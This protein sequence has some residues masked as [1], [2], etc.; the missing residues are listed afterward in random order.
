MTKKPLILIV[1]LIVLVVSGIVVWRVEDTRAKAAKI[2]SN[3]LKGLTTD[4]VK[5]IVENQAL[6]DPSK[7]L[8]IVNSTDSRKAFM[9]GL[10]EYLALA[11]KARRE[12]MAD[13]PNVKLVLQNKEKGLLTDLYLTKAD[14]DGKVIDRVT[15]EQIEAIWTDPKNEEE[16]KL[17]VAAGQVVQKDTAEKTEN[18]MGVS[19][20]LQGGTL[21]KFRKGWARI[22]IISDMARADHDFMQERLTQLR[23]KILEAGVLSNSC[24]AKYWKEEIKA[25]DREIAAYL[26]EHPEYS[27]AKKR[28]KAETILNRLKAGEDFEALAKQFSEHR[29]TQENGGTYDENIEGPLAPEVKSVA[30]QL[31][32][33]QLADRVIETAQGYEIIQLVTKSDTGNSGNG[34]VVFKIRRILLQKLFEDPDIRRPDIPAPFVSNIEIA[35]AAVQKQKRD[36]FVASVIQSES[37]SMPDD[38]DFEPTEAM[39]R[40]AADENRIGDLIRKDQEEMKTEAKKPSTR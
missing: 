34:Q 18:P 5:L 32:P 14:Q 22:K 23:L 16:F 29:S 26:N 36:E 31:K 1:A 7:A 17:E 9:K 4:D 15:D 20:P 21:E 33:G 38:F 19:P 3:I 2:E 13:D 30:L 12:G 11:A 39:K 28:E 25:A 40:I 35:R 6:M 10:T 24:L 37:I 8:S 27:L